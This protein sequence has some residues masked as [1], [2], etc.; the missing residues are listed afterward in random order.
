MLSSVFME[1]DTERHLSIVLQPMSVSIYMHVHIYDFAFGS[2][3]MTIG[4]ML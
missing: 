3:G 2:A 4:Q 1:P